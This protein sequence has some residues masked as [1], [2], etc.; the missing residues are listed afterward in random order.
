MESRPSIEE[1]R[2]LEGVVDAEWVDPPRRAVE[3]M[4]DVPD[5]ELE[6][7]SMLYVNGMYLVETVQDPGA[8][9]MGQARPDGTI[10][11]WG[12]YGPLRETSGASRQHHNLRRHSR[13][14][15]QAKR[16][17]LGFVE[18]WQGELVGRIVDQVDEYTAGRRDLHKLVEDTRGLFDAADVSDN[19][20]RGQFESVWAPISGQLELRTEDWSKTEWV[21][22]EE[23]AAAL[24]E[25][26]SW[27]AKVSGRNAR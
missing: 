23:L 19:E 24:A 1:V 3:P 12:I 5:R 8:W 15:G 10:E 13:K 4:R 7:V 21:S 6:V 9:W 2:R 20:I 22:D 27:A 17:T 25:L 14:L 18:S 11:C 26:R 16:P